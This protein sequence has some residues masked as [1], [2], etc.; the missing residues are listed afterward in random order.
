MRFYTGDAGPTQGGG[1]LDPTLVPT[2][3]EY[4]S[5]REVDCEILHWWRWVHQEGG[6]CEIPHWLEKG[7]KHFLQDVKTSL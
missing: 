2:K 4:W 3:R 7:I 5:S 1:L 6:D